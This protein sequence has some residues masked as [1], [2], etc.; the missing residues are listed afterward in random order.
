MQRAKARIWI[1]FLNSR[2]HPAASDIT[3]D[4]EPDKALQR[5]QQHLSTLEKEMGG[6]RFIVGD[7]SLADVS[8]IPFYARR[9]RYGVTIDD[10]YP[11]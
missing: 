11:N 7:Y 5:L 2:V 10:N 9:Q 6:K 1:D 8:F 3:H 4:R